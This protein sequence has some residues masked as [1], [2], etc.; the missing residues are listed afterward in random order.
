[1][2]VIQIIHERIHSIEERL[3]SRKI[4]PQERDRLKSQL[5][6]EQLE[7]NKLLNLIP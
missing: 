3:K 6:I 4:T 7:M 2:K 5:L 1:M